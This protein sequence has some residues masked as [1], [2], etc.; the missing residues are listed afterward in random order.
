MRLVKLNEPGFAESLRFTPVPVR[1]TDWVLPVELLS[2]KVNVPVRAP[3]AR[4][5]KA[6][7]TVQLAPAAKLRLQVLAVET[8]LPVRLMELMVNAPVPVLVKVTTWA[9]VVLLIFALPKDKVVGE[10]F[11]VGT[12]T[13]PLSVTT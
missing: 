2:P 12:C 1:L 6:T 10:T 9:A 4:G 7:E 3:A 11:A 8:K 5:E 13:V